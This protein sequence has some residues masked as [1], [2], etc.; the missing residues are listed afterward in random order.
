MHDEQI[1]FLGQYAS[2]KA[3]NRRAAE[4]M[5]ELGQTAGYHGP[6]ERLAG[7]LSCCHDA[8]VMARVIA[9][10]NQKGGVGKTTTTINIGIGL[11]ERGRS[12][13]LID[14]DPQGSLTQGLGIDPDSLSATTYDALID[15]ETPLDWVFLRVRSKVVL[16]PASID[17]A[18]AE[19]ELAATPDW[20][21]TL[22]RRL[23]TI[24]TEADFILIDC[25]T[26][27]GV[28]TVNALVAA[29]EV[30]VPAECSFLAFRGLSG[31][32][33]TIKGIQAR[34]NPRLKIATILP[35]KVPRTV[36]AREALDE[37]R[38]ICGPL[39]S[40]III[41]QRVKVADALISGKSILEFDPRSDAA[42]AF[43]RITEVIDHG[44]KGV[45][46]GARPRGGLRRI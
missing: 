1:T 40:D 10:A 36:H 14:F 16:A 20:Q 35:V 18:G 15:E 7:A 12:V 2:F 22:R 17:L 11:S 28:L 5:C 9:I 23:I 32:L 25:P 19:F 30:V 44:E 33:A 39:V 26:S 41:P 21:Q 46:E 24:K 6:R 3:R 31:L 38:R 29:N 43:R 4:S 45:Y 42:E 37:L 13:I 8:A 34:F 27:L